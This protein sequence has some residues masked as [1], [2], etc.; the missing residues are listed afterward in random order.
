MNKMVPHVLVLPEDDANRQLANGFQL[1]Y[2]LDTRRIQILE[3]AGGWRQVL[4]RLKEVHVAEME[5]NPNRFMVLLVDFDRQKN[6]FREIA[7]E[8][9]TH[10]SE[11]VFVLG[12]WSQ[13]EELRQALGSYE[14]IGLAMAKDCRENTDAIWKHTLLTHNAEELDRLRQ[15]I[16]PILFP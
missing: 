3:A 12:T 13:P 14:K 15:R 2:S 5:R 10:L 7:A 6:R 1:D 9:P 4:E 8:I 16:R 11:R